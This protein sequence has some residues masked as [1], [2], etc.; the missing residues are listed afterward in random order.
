MITGIDFSQEI[1]AINT[2]KALKFSLKHRRKH[3][4]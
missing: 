1:F 2:L 3:I 4:L